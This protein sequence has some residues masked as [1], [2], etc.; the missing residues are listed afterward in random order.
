MAHRRSVVEGF[1]LRESGE[2]HLDVRRPGCFHVKDYVLA[3]VGISL[4]SPH[5]NGRPQSSQ[6]NLKTRIHHYPGQRWRFDAE[7]HAR[8][9]AQREP[10]NPTAARQER[11]ALHIR[12]W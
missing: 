8:L 10:G 5:Q 11:R 1:D 2:H 9:P 3:Y 4:K 7:T 12:T 6:T